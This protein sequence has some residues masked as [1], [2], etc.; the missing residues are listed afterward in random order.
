LRHPSGRS[1]LTSYSGWRILQAASRRLRAWLVVQGYG[2]KMIVRAIG[3][4]AAA[5]LMMA[6]PA[7]ALA[8]DLL[9]DLGMEPITNIYTDTTTIPGHTLLWYGALVANAGAGPFEVSGTRAST[10][11]Q[12]MAVAQDVYQS[13]GGFRSVPTTDVFGYVS[14]EWRLKLLEKGWLSTLT[15]TQVGVLAKHW[16]CPNDDVAY[17]LTLPGAPQT[18]VYRSSC[19]HGNTSLLS[20]IDG[21]SVGWADNYPAT[22]VNQ[23]IDITGVPD[24]VYKLFSKA[25]PR[26]Y[27]LESND[28]NNQTWTEIQL[29][30]GTVTILNYG[31]HI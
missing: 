1:G 13:G 4:L 15:G 6:S 23:Y 14:G 24:G 10:S 25:D 22:T 20:T 18:R 12:Y 16:Y 5:L 27:F 21:I 19:G 29:Q 3:S 30:A 9:P 28:S 17:N 31:P 8:S 7:P 26:N 11:D 2:G